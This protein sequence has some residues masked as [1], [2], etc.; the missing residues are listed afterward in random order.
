MN[1]VLYFLW[2]LFIV[3]GGI[4]AGLFVLYVSVKVCAWAVL[5]AR[6]EFSKKERREQHERK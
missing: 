5:T 3:M 2:L 4:P 1:D 6:A